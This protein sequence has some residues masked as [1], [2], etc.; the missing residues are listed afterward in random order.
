MFEL[1]HLKR[2]LLQP[3]IIKVK[4]KVNILT[5]SCGE[6]RYAADVVIGEQL[7]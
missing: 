7:A 1:G 5:T 2:Q 6:C 3:D 4:V